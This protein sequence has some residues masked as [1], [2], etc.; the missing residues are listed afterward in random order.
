MIWSNCHWI[1][2]RRR[3]EKGGLVLKNA[4]FVRQMLDFIGRAISARVILDS[5]DN[6]HKKTIAA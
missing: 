4:L 6:F 5:S 1:L 2:D 3:L